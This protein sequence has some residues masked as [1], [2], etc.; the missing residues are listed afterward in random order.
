V[1]VNFAIPTEH[2]R[3][4]GYSSAD[5]QS[6]RRRRLAYDDLRCQLHYPGCTERATSVHLDPAL[7]GDHSKA[8]M[9]N[10]ASA[11]A[12]CHGVEDAPTSNG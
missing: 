7:K 10:T 12:H 6:L 2:Q 5:W 8:T 1:R 9:E 11:C 3:D 4:N